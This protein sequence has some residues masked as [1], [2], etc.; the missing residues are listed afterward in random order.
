V[1]VNQYEAF[2]V[3]VSADDRRGQPIVNVS[4]LT[5]TAAGGVSWARTRTVFFSHPEERLAWIKSKL[6]DD[7]K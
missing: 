6:F 5:R 4:A 3:Q 1:F 2:E 7:A